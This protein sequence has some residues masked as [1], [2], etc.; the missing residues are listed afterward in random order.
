MFYNI[1]KVFLVIHDLKL[2]VNE[3]N[4]QFSNSIVVFVVLLLKISL[5]LW[6]D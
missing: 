5:V 1:T 4:I 6:Q 3:N 2:A